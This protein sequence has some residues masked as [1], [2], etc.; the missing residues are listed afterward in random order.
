MTWLSIIVL[1]CTVGGGLDGAVRPAGRRA[2]YRAG[3]YDAFVRIRGANREVLS[4]R[5]SSE[6]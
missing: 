5:H 2:A 6:R 4:E 1:I 3:M